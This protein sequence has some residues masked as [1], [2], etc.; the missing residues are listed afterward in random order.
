MQPSSTG[1]LNHVQDKVISFTSVSRWWLLAKS[2]KM[3]HLNDEHFINS[4]KS[5]HWF[6]YIAVIAFV[7]TSCFMCWHR[8]VIVFEK[9]LRLFNINIIYCNIQLLNMLSRRSRF[10][11]LSTNSNKLRYIFYTMNIYHSVNKIPC[12]NVYTVS[13]PIIRILL[14]I[15]SSLRIK[16]APLFLILY[17]T[18]RYIR[19]Y[20][21]IYYYYYEF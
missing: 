18:L 2:S 11:R 19:P 3:C 13:P 16:I 4:P 7:S 20:N 21:T 17:S 6:L 5:N 12:I 8:K 10:Q 1:K 9:D 14:H 15:A